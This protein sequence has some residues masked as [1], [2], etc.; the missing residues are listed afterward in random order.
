MIPAGMQSPPQRSDLDGILPANG[1]T[2]ATVRAV[3]FRRPR[4][5]LARFAAEVA[6]IAR[7]GFIDPEK[8]K[9]FE[10]LQ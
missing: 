3:G 6:I 8:R 4:S 9:T 10:N 7:F 5:H 1:Q 2:I